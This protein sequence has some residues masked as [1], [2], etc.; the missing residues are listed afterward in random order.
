MPEVLARPMA[1][2]PIIELATLPQRHPET[3]GVILKLFGLAF[4]HRL[5]MDPTPLSQG[6][7]VR[8]VTIDRASPK[9]DE[10][11]IKEVRELGWSG[12]TGASE[13]DCVRLPRVANEQRITEDAAIAVMALLIHELESVTVERVLEIGSGGDYVLSLKMRGESAQAEV[14][15]VREDRTGAKSRARLSE[16]LAQVLRQC[17]IG[18]VSVTT[19]CR[20]KAG[21]VHS[22]LHYVE[23]GKGGKRKGRRR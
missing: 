13:D 16:K 23:R 6:T 11:R 22:Y 7:K 3:G 14:S 15:G 12:E 17:P 4:V 9:T 2:G 5:S 10:K 20:L 21:I 19:F 8:E 18:F 1:N